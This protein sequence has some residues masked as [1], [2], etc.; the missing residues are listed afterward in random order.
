ME[1]GPSYLFTGLLE[2]PPDPTAA[3][4]VKWAGLCAAIGVD[5]DATTWADVANELCAAWA[6][7]ETRDCRELSF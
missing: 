4:D 6:L 5:P 3:R 7:T 1:P 2:P